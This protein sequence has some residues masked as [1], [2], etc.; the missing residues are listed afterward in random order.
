[1]KTSTFAANDQVKQSSP[2]TDKSNFCLKFWASKDELKKE[3]ELYLPM[4]KEKHQID[5][6]KALMKL[7]LEL[8][9]RF[10]E[11]CEHV[12]SLGNIG[13]LPRKLKDE[14]DLLKFSKF[15]DQ[16]P[17]KTRILSSELYTIINL[18]KQEE[19]SSK[20]N[21]SIQNLSGLKTKL[22]KIYES[23]CR[24]LKTESS[25]ALSMFE[26]DV[27]EFSKKIHQATTYSL[28][29]VD[30]LNEKK[31]DHWNQPTTSD[32]LGKLFS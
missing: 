27:R 29:Y 9:E 17:K 31:I 24:Q 18:K 26:K 7:K 14:R 28:N 5:R 32:G 22:E 23:V 21:S 25:G 1:M 13:G 10:T 16:F 20:V 15:A 6:I 2:L 4:L 3:F 30:R 8:E 19:R 12:R 11:W